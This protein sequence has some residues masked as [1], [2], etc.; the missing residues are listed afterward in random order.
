VNAINRAAA[1]HIPFKQVKCTSNEKDKSIARNPRYK[2]IKN[3]KRIAKKVKEIPS[4]EEE[5]N[6]FLWNCQIQEINNRQESLVKEV[7][8]EQQEE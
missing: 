1:K 8:V 2:D 4:L 6:R 7:N 3:L 5:V